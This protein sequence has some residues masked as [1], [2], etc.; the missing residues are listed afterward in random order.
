M[1]AAQ[2]LLQV[3]NRPSDVRLID[4]VWLDAACWTKLTTSSYCLWWR[5][6][7]LRRFTSCRIQY[8]NE[9]IQ[10]LCIVMCVRWQL[11]VSQFLG[12]VERK[13]KFGGTNRLFTRNLKLNL[14]GSSVKSPL[15]IC[16]C[17]V[18]VYMR[19]FGWRSLCPGRGQWEQRIFER[20]PLWKSEL[21]CFGG[22]SWTDHEYK[23]NKLLIA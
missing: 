3:A 2:Q 14:N 12:A 7:L 5:R 11:Q 19:V 1:S 17:Y 6:H 9:V 21:R 18:Y 22:E 15:C 23:N 13:A 10:R 4:A 8:H 20:I 16:V